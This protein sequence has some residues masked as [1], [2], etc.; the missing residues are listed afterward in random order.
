MLLND[1]LLECTHTLTRTHTHTLSNTHTHT[2]THMCVQLDH[3]TSQKTSHSFFS[4]FFFFL[5]NSLTSTWLFDL[6][7]SLIIRASLTFGRTLSFSPS[8]RFF[9]LL[10]ILKNLLLCQTVKISVQIFCY[11]ILPNATLALAPPR[12]Y[13]GSARPSKLLTSGYTRS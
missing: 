6:E 7:S 2:H 1:I 4:L 10:F 13:P 12:G 3:I 8:W 5:F 9:L 11:D